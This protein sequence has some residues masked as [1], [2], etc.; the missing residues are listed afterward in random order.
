MYIVMVC[1]KEKVIV[2]WGHVNILGGDK[3][4]R[5]I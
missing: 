3:H 2:V 4:E 1:M 5:I